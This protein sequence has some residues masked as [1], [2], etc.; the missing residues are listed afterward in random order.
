MAIRA[1]I[2]DLGGVL[3]HENDTGMDAKWE[4]RLGLKQGTLTERLFTSG[5]AIDATVGKYSEEEMLRRLGELYELDEAQV[6][7]FMNDLWEQYSLNSEL[8]EFFKS[9]RPRYRTAILTNAWPDARREEHERFHFDEMT[10]LIVY[11]YEEK[12]GKPNAPIFQVTCER[13]GVK[14]EEVVFLDNTESNVTAARAL[15]MQAILFKN[16]AQAIA[17]VQACLDGHS[18]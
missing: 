14:P 3:E 10:D 2:F 6:R 9:L 4:K 15:G 8:A 16:T 12:D 7:E 5:F 18:E 1:V 17:D 11:S 13:L